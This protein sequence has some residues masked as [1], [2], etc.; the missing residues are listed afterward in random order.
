MTLKA[1]SANPY[2][3]VFNN[4]FRYRDPDGRFVM[5]PL[6]IWGAELILPSLTAIAAPIVYGAFAGAVAYGGYKIAQAVNSRDNGYSFANNYAPSSMWFDVS[7]EEE[8]K[9]KYNINPFDGPV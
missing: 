1:D 2:Q 9:K 6:L 7:C 8:K 3:Y 4:P 5:F